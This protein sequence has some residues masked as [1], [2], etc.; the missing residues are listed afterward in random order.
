MHNIDNSTVN[1]FGDEWGRFDQSSLDSSEAYRRFQEYF[2][3]FP[4]D[5]VSSESTGFDMG[6]GS[7]RWSQ[8][9]APKVGQLHCIDP[10]IDALEVAR[11]N[12]HSHANVSFHLA[13]V[14]NPPLRL[15]SQDFGVSL[16]VLHHVPD[17]ESAINSCVSLL[18]PGAPLL[19]YLYYSFDNRPFWFRY[20]WKISDCIRLVVY[21]LPSSIKNLVCDFFA[22]SIYM[23]L[24]LLSRLFEKLG[25]DVTNLPLSYYRHCSFYSIRTDSRDR[26]GTPLEHRFSRK[27]ITEMCHRCG[28]KNVIFSSSAPYWCLVGIKA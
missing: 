13:S 27:E 9:L 17:T 1:S 16:G 2:S 28:L 12:L 20:I 22:L 26:F 15:S 24:I 7:G 19:L 14:D 4:W 25:F 6:C 23:P 10:S 3:V 21:R 11:T 8:Y 5:L 18:K